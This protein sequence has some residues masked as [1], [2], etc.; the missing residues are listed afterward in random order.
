VRGI[1]SCV[2]GSRCRYPSAV[3]APTPT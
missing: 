3:R 1:T 2:G